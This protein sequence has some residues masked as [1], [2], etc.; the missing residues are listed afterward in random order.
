MLGLLKVY[1]SD[2]TSA[3]ALDNNISMEGEAIYAESLLING[4]FDNS[5][6]EIPTRCP[7]LMLYMLYISYVSC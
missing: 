7:L 3:A 5:K 4:D 2:K 6:S 1:N